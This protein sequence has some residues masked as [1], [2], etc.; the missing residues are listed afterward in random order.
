MPENNNDV[1]PVESASDSQTEQNV[2]KDTSQEASTTAA[3]STTESGDSDILT[4]AK[5]L[6]KEQTA[7]QAKVEDREKKVEEEVDETE[8]AV[9]A[10]EEETKIVEK[11]EIDETKP[12]PYERFKEVNS[13]KTELEKR[14]NEVQPVIDAQKALNEFC[15]SNNVTPE[16]FEYWVNVAALVKTNPQRALEFLKPQLEQLQSFTG[17]RLTPELQAAVDNG[18][19][20]L[21]WAKKIAASESQTK[22]QTKTAKLTQEQQSQRVQLEY[23][24]S[25]DSALTKW[26]ESKQTKIPEF[27]PKVGDAADGLLELWAYKFAATAKTAKISSPDELVALADKSLIELQSSL[28]RFSPKAS[29]GPKV[30][31]TQAR[32]NSSTKPI[33]SISDAVSAALKKNGATVIS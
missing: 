27:K 8:K 25:L 28:S 11:E 18:E 15:Q 17:D 30:S 10:D 14:W 4:L 33:N 31:S 26:I 2:V 20:S 24:Q 3:Q 22:H 6:V 23:S 1:K 7:S 21:D 29:T 16:E 5:N 19:I 32:S 9:K 12:V 13:T